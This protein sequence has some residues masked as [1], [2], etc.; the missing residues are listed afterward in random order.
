MSQKIIKLF[1]CC[2]NWSP[3]TQ[4]RRL[5]DDEVIEMKILNDSSGTEKLTTKDNDDE[6]DAPKVV[7]NEA[8]SSRN[9][10]ICNGQDNDKIEIEV[11][12]EKG[13]TPLRRVGLA[14]SGQAM[15]NQ[16]S[17]SDKTFGS[18]FSQR[19][20]RP[21]AKVSNVKIQVADD[22][23]GPTLAANQVPNIQR[24]KPKTPQLRRQNASESGEMRTVEIKQVDVGLE[25]NHLF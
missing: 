13:H 25:T 20:Q 17:T 8:S 16:N 1:Q 15:D 21:G 19:L 14:K 18:S 11:K 24:P 23:Q 6:V 10:G 22:Y 9:L 5:D 3:Y 2:H 7:N 4:S 12:P